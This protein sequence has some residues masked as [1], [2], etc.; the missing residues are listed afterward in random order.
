[1]VISHETVS[2]HPALRS[3]GASFRATSEGPEDKLVRAFVED[4][5]DN[6]ASQTL[7]K[8]REL[9]LGSW[10]PDL[11][12]VYWSPKIAGGWPRSRLRLL[13]SDFRVLQCLRGLG[14]AG[15]DRLSQFAGQETPASLERL[16]AADLVFRASH[17]WRPRSVDDSF[18]VDRLV[19]IEAK[20][21]NW[22]TGLKQAARNRWFA[23]ESYLLLDVFPSS[24]DLVQEA[25]ALDVGL[26]DLEGHLSEPIKP[27]TAKKLPGSYASWLINDWA[28]RAQA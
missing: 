6:S 1:M 4:L 2:E 3:G 9:Q 20:V 22:R 23:S 19:A 5:P 24:D 11:I 16:A 14:Q 27:P 28:W 17:T 25:K 15:V 12:L 26:L 13:P 18:A 21:K 7:T 8:F 10:F